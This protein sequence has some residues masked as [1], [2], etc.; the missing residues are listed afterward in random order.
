MLIRFYSIE[1][2]GDVT[3]ESLPSSVTIEVD[4]GMDAGEI[5][6]N[7]A[8]M[9]E[10]EFGVSVDSYEWEHIDADEQEVFSFDKDE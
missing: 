6:M 7:G 2:S 1:W 9:L 10:E 5:E 4:D 3:S 8:D